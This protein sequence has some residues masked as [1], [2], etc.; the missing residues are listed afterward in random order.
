[1]KLSI[2]DSEVTIALA[3]RVAICI[4]WVSKTRKDATVSSNCTQPR[5]LDV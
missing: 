1:M 2:R 5:Y 3:D 4:Y